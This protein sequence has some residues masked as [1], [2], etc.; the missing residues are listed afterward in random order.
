MADTYTPDDVRA[1]QAIYTPR[2]LP[3]YD[4]LVLGFS[5]RFVWR[6][7]AAR[8]LER[9]DRFVS[10]NHLE[11]GVGS[12]YFL[13][14][15]RFP[16][17]EPRITLVDLNA[18]CLAA[19]ARRIARYRPAQFV[20]NALEP[21]EL[22]GQ[23]FDSAGINFVLHCVPGTIE[24]KACIFDHIRAVMK[25]GSV[26]FGSTVLWQGVN[27]GMLARNLTPIYNRRRIFANL[28]DS[29]DGLRAILRDRFPDHELHTV[30]SVALF[31]ARVP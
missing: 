24:T 2:T 7:P 15:C 11:V 17:N 28:S 19:T 21:F 9:Y 13:D 14:R 18:D 20:R 23:S 25:P 5:C 1:G 26:I 4:L 8:V 27:H 29:L 16:V 6:C 12:G 31:H 10:A 30:G 22:D 3:W